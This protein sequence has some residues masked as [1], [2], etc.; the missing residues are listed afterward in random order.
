M[1]FLAG[2]FRSMAGR[3][4]LVLLFGSWLA[5]AFSFWIA[6]GREASHFA[7][8][9]GHFAADRIAHWLQL[10]DTLPPQ[11]RQALLPLAAREETRLK[12]ALPPPAMDKR[13]V[14]FL[15][16]RLQ[17][18]LGTAIHLENVRLEEGGCAPDQEEG[19]CDKARRVVA[20]ARL[21]DGTPATVELLDRPPRRRSPALDRFLVQMAIFA[22]ALALLAGGV[23][24]WVT[25]P[26]RRMAKAALSL[27]RNIAQPPLP[28]AGPAEVRDASRAFNR[29]QSQIRRH[30]EERTGILAAITHD[31]QTPLTRMRLRL[32]NAPA[33]PRRDKL[34][35]DLEHMGQMVKEGLDLARSLDAPPPSQLLAIDSLVYSV[36]ED[37]AD[38]GQKVTCSGESLATVRA[39]P[40]D[41]RRCL[42]NLLTNAVN[43]GDRADVHIERSDTEVRIRIKDAGPGIPADQLERVLDP[44][45]RLETSRSR[46]T[47]GTGLGLTIAHNIA[48]GHGGSLT[49]RNGQDGGLEATLTLPLAEVKT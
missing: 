24:Y 30:V 40:V 7:Q 3:V 21:S 12:L 32:E 17:E 39:R 28:E 37:L 10:L 38:A 6:S 20:S 5:F 11:E 48:R 2:F 27:G 26:L 41:L 45:V 15:R 9:R 44:F 25:R 8:L 49:L 29:M 42:T 22:V 18:K 35:Q 1:R 46:D 43:Y 47:G 36:C 13:E 14:P 33:D 19:S 34:L 31:L 4:F 16:D 23:A